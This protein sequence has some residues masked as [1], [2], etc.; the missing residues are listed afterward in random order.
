MPKLIVLITPQLEAGY[1]IAEEWQSHGAP[2]VTLIDGYGLFRLQEATKKSEVLPGMLSML[3]IVRSR[4]NNNIILLSVVENLTVVDELIETA[5]RMLGGL[6]EP[7]NGI[8]FVLDVD[9]VV[10]LRNT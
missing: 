6:P 3:E 10:G 9:K 5:D 4:Q 2:G 7:D 1:E 8:V